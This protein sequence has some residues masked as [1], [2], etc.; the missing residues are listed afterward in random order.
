VETAEWCLSSETTDRRRPATDRAAGYTPAITRKAALGFALV[1][2]LALIGAS[3]TLLAPDHPKRKQ[4]LMEFA[5]DAT[6]MYYLME[7]AQ[8]GKKAFLEK[9]NPDFGKFP[10]FP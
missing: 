2:F 8:E 1:M 7:E 6:L 3:V 5:R 9:R 10:I 4:A